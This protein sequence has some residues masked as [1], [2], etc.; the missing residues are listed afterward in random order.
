[1]YEKVAKEKIAHYNEHGFK[2]WK[3]SVTDKMAGNGARDPHAYLD[4][5]HDMGSK[6]FAKSQIA[7]GHEHMV[8]TGK[9]MVIQLYTIHYDM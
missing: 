4:S 8:N 1:M 6:A 2:A 5:L 7:K 9:V 3:R